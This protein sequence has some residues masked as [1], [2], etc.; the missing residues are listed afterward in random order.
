MPSTLRAVIRAGKD[1]GDVADCHAL[2][3][4]T[5]GKTPDQTTASLRDAI[6]LLFEDASLTGDGSSAWPSSITLDLGPLAHAG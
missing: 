2:P 3:V 5:Q 1:N 4:V 6:A